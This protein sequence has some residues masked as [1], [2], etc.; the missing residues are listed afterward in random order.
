MDLNT[1]KVLNN[2][3]KMPIFG[4]GVY[5]S[6]DGDETY[7]AVRWALEAG[8]RHIDTAAMYGNEAS[9][10]RA[11]RDSGIAREE[12]FVTTKLWNSEIREHNEE[13]ALK[14]SLE[15]LGMDYV[16]LYIYHM[17][18]WNTP[19]YDI[20]DG[21]DRVVAEGLFAAVAK[22]GGESVSLTACRHGHLSFKHR[23]DKGLIRLLSVSGVEEG[24]IDIGASI[25]K[26]GEHEALLGSG[27][28]LV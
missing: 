26:A 21:L 17:W 14:A 25:V 10:G 12:I 13:N 9:V 28:H 22:E 3:V 4:L 23:I 6:A 5:K 24:V 8:Y 19:L 11:I 2:G 20:M 27:H 7:N 1:V 18:D 16:D 15:K